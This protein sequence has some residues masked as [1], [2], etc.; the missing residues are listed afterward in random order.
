MNEN[1]VR[2]SDRK[3][4]ASRKSVRAADAH[5]HAETIGHLVLTLRGCDV[6]VFIL[7]VM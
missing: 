5:V 1:Q 3:T 6:H 4:E 2:T 7:L